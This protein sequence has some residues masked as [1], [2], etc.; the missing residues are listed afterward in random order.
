MKVQRTHMKSLKSPSLNNREY[1]F[2]TA[3]VLKMVAQTISISVLPT[4]IGQDLIYRVFK[5]MTYSSY[6]LVVI[7]F[8]AGNKISIRELV[9]VAMLVCITALGSYYA[10]N[11]IMLSLIYIY[12][13]RKINLEK[14]FLYAGSIY[15]AIFLMI[16]LL[17]LAGIIE[18]W[19]FFQSSSRPRWGLGYSY[20]THTSSVLF[21]CVLIFCYLK[22][23]RLNLVW[24]A[25]IELLNV[26]VFLF[27]DSRAGFILS[28]VVPFVFLL[29]KY[30]RKYLTESKVE[31]I[32][33]WAF[34]ICA[35]AIYSMTMLY[36]GTGVLRLI[37]VM[38]STRL[39]TAQSSI[40]QYGIHLFGQRIQ[41]VGW[42][43]WGHTQIEL[44]GTYNYV[45]SSYLK[46]LLDNGIIIWL[47]IMIG[48]TT[49][50]I[51][52]YKTNNRYLVY[53]L[54]FLAVY[55]MVEQW[56]MNLGANPFVI[57]L[58]LFLFDNVNNNVSRKSCEENR[59]KRL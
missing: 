56:L 4:M 42:G 24:T 30:R 1:I 43:G 29:L 7:S 18:N 25:L 51:K 35:I 19:D 22:K 52:A 10:G 31:K 20:P 36:D 2:L 54:S 49:V 45:D 12:G 26:W 59:T 37:N 44:T 11:E 46:L 41:W 55:C 16:I 3:V 34:P 17:S 5:V 47:I 32:L 39:S 48:W 13:A 53:A 14:I 33:Q 23:E 38:I 21:M 50:S 9:Q 58:A 57:F 8:L 40:K 27:T 28:A 15:I 6:L